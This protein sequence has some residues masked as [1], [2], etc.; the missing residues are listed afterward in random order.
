LIKEF[1]HEIW[2][3]GHSKY[4]Q[5]GA[6]DQVEEETYVLEGFIS[7]QRLSK[8]CLVGVAAETVDEL[9]HEV[10]L[11]SLTKPGG[12]AGRWLPDVPF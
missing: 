5:E 6:E 1:H 3:G 10:S 12:V 11:K 8:G 9:C 4:A 2:A 7:S